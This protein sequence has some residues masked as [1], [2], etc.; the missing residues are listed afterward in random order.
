MTEG[1]R[2]PSVEALIGDFFASGWEE[3]R[4][5]FLSPGVCEP[6]AGVQFL[7][8]NALS[9]VRPNYRGEYRY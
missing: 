1:V 3:I 6:C 4:S 9:E 7:L 5:D 8:G 2:E